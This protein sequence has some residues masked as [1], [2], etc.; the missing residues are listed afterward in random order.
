VIER[1]RCYVDGQWR[2]AE[3]G[4]EFPIRDPSSGSE[5]ARASRADASLIEH[6]A[7][8]ARSAFDEY[9]WVPAYDRAALCSRVAEL[10]DK[11]RDR[12]AHQLCEEHGKPFAEARAEVGF[13][14]SGMQLFAEEARRLEGRAPAVADPTKRALVVRQARGTWAFLTP[15]NFPLNIPV[16]YIGPALATGCT[17]VWKPAP[18]TARIAVRLMELLV[19]AGV[20]DGVANLVL[21]DDTAAAERLVTDPRITAVGLTGGSGTGARVAQLAWDKHLLLELGGNTPVLVLSDADAVAAAR[22]IVDASFFNAGQVCTATGRVIVADAIADD[23][24]SEVAREAGRVVVGAPLEPDTT[25]GPVHTESIAAG[26]ERDVDDATALG[27]SVITGGARAPELGSP[28]FFRPTVLDHVPVEARAFQ[29]ET[30]GPVAPIV[31]AGADA[32]VLALANR[33]RHGLAA[34][35]FTRSLGSAFRLAE[36]VDAGMVSVNGS[37]NY[38]E[39]QLPFGGWAGTLSGRGRLG[40]TGALDEFTQSK[41]ITFDIGTDHAHS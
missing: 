28:L 8:A 15:W 5:I 32:D 4:G 18:T 27:A 10:L 22:A 38:W 6:A 21:I 17:F 26:L 31:R 35:V 9:R 41:L 40:G 25:M 20:P 11:R 3:S 1:L 33:A 2:D 34:A 16:E 12:L 7:S 29:E 19:E 24:V 30:F 39:H 37:S 36:R 23:L 14:V 13:A